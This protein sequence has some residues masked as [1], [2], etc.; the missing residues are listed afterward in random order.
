MAAN[1]KSG[2]WNDWKAQHPRWH[3]L[4]VLELASI[5]G[6]LAAGLIWLFGTDI[7]WFWSENRDGLRDL[8]LTLVAVIG[9]PLLIWREKRDIVLPT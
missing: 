5:T 8:G 7:W 9:L 2:F 6:L 3:R 4:L 1:D